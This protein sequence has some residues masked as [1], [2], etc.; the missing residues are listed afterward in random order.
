MSDE[1]QMAEQAVTNPAPD[2]IVANATQALAIQEL[3]DGFSRLKKQVKTLWISVI[4]IAVL[5]V[6]L[7]VS[8]VVPRFLGGGM[9]G[10]RGNWSGRTGTTTGTTNGGTWNGTTPG[11]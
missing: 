10:G 6:A 4:V 9:M 5:V 8:T 7:A 11:Q 3:N 2:P 1:T